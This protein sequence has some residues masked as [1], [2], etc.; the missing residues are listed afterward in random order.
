M[1]RT[2]PNPLFLSLFVLSLLLGP[3]WAEADPIGF[4]L[5]TG[6]TEAREVQ[7]DLGPRGASDNVEVLL[8]SDA[9]SIQPGKQFL[10]A[11]HMK[12]DSGWHTYWKNPG[13]SGLPLKIQW[14]L[15][16]GFTPG[17]IQWPIP[18]RIPEPPLMGYG[19]H[20]DVLFTVPIMPPK[21]ITAGNVRIAGTFD[22]LECKDICIPGAAKLA[23]TLP[24]ESASRPSSSA[25]LVAAGQGALP[26]TS[27][28]WDFSASAGKEI[29]LTAK[30]PKEVT[31]S[32]LEFFPNEGLV[33][34]SAAP[35]RLLSRDGTHK[36]S[37]APDPNAEGKPSRLTGVLIYT[38]GG[39]RQGVV[40]DVP[41]SGSAA[42][43]GTTGAAGASGWPIALTFA[44][45]GGLILNL[46]PCVLP[47][48]SLKVLGIVEHSGEGNG[49][50]WR[51]GVAYAFGVLA[52]FWALAAILL[53]LRGAGQHVG[54]GFQLQSAPFL[55]FLSGLFLILALNLFGMFEIGAS[56]TRAS[57]HA[58][59][60]AGLTGSFGSGVLATIA[61]T[62]CTAP[63]MGSALGFA[64]GQP[65]AMTLLIFTALGLG[66]AV[67]YVVLTA[68]P[69]LLRFVPR[70]GPWM[71]TMKHVMGF[72]LLAVVVALVWLFGQL[73]G[74]DGVG[75]LLA[76]L[77]LMGA[78][79]WALGHA[80]TG[81]GG[82]KA[83]GLSY[84]SA[85]VLLL[86]GLG[87]GI[88]GTKAMAPA[89]PTG[90][91][92]AGATGWEP[93]SS[94]RVEALRAEGKP[95]F[96]DFTAAWC[97]TCQVNER[98]ALANADVAKR[99]QDHGVVLL[100]ADWTRRDDEITQ[101][102]AG[103]GRQG[104]PVYIL[105][106]RESGSAP[107]FLPELLTP[108]IVLSALDE[109][110]GPAGAAESASF[111]RGHATGGTK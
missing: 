34:E 70:P 97:L 83:R 31:F 101:A 103:Y 58:G 87:F 48:L 105:Y 84:A 38:S 98:V 29:V 67:P 59:K 6:S 37:M 5:G 10:V 81:R 15:P 51:H 111:T 66:M 109:T 44:F 63:F 20:G 33:I 1:T 60:T 9:A 77:L 4:D 11:L 57:G 26:T 89:A 99:F 23:I 47:V 55:A 102:L 30:P 95:V 79:V 104:V 62:P 25:S 91:E 69:A 2:R 88:R 65:A 64:L 19:Y 110:L 75:L 85:V 56:L 7:T 22:W 90:T 82:S 68:S 41:V 52:T 74:I 27:L 16:P 71:K 54:W 106:G 45:L 17:E 18:S 28:G 46:M 12:L 53:M 94:A 35:Q 14:E 61:A 13:D 76:A 73:T 3:A 96:I 80:Q 43:A 32:A 24:V 39:A 50:A 100:K 92:T 40:I 107:R 21:T 86:A 42:A 93:Y 49:R 36:L 78:G 108:A 8:L 72:L